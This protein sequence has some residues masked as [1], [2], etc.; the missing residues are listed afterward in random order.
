MKGGQRSFLQHIETLFDAGAIGEQ[1][2]RQL[3]QLFTGR[4]RTAAELAFAVL[5]KRHGPMVFRACQAILHNPHAAEDAFQGTFLVLARKAA[6]LWVR[7]SLGPWLLSVARRVA[8]CARTDASRR[9]A[10]ERT[11]AELAAPATEDRQWDDRNVI[12]HEELGRLPEKYR[13][14]VLLCDLEGLTQEQAARHLG[15]PGGTVRSRLARGRHQLRYRL[16]RR[17]MAP[18]VVLA[19]QTPII[20]MASVSLVEKTVHAALQIASGRADIGAT[21]SA[22]A[23]ME[24]V[25][26]IMSFSNL[27]MTAS[28]ALA[29]ALLCGT[30]LMGYRAMGLPQAPAAAGIQRPRAQGDPKGKPTVPTSSSSES[31]ELDAIGTARIAIAAKL[32]DAAHRLWQ[33]GETNVGDYLTAQ[34]RYDEVMADVMVKTDADRVRFLEREVTTLKQIEERMRELFRRGQCTERDLLTTELARLDA[35]YALTKA[36]SKARGTSK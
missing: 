7:S 1:T 3:L 9:R 12:L 17:G 26:K 14:A 15:W 19:G 24:G 10:H 22:M 6:R 20:D 18:T 8:Y 32:R 35:D 33:G 28:V 4:D 34:K 2:D 5:V 30:G 27:K 21:A 31:L 36:K 23:L 16:T 13:T 11:A 29:S 25:L